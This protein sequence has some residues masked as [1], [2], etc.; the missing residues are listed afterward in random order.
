MSHSCSVDVVPFIARLPGAWSSAQSFE[1]L[2]D[3]DLKKLLYAEQYIEET[4][5]D[6]E[7]E[8]FSE[9]GVSPIPTT[10][11]GWTI[12]QEVVNFGKK[13]QLYINWI[14][15]GDF[16]V[17]ELNESQYNNV[18]CYEVGIIS[19]NAESLSEFINDFHD[20][21]ENEEDAPMVIE[22]NEAVQSWG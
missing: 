18:D 13:K 20:C 9:D 12:D 4:A 11:R 2:P 1:D 7:W 6:E 21:W 22:K 16:R 5:T 10:I 8:K 19:E 3:N 15:K 17:A 14:S